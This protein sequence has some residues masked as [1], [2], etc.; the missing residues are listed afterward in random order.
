MTAIT[1][2]THSALR[3]LRGVAKRV[4]TCL[5]ACLTI[6][7]LSQPSVAV[8][9]GNDDSYDQTI[10]VRG[11]NGKIYNKQQS[12]RADPKNNPYGLSIVDKVQTRGSDTRSAD[13]QLN[14]MPDLNKFVNTNL[15]ERVNYSGT[16]G[17][18]IDPANLQLTTDAEVR[19]YFVSEGAGY[20]NMLGFN[21]DS[22]GVDAD[23]SRLIFPD[24]SVPNAFLK[25]DPKAKRSRK[26]PVLPGDF[27]DLGTFSAGQ[28]LDFFLIADDKK[29]NHPVYDANPATNPDG[30]NHMVAF[31]YAI[32]D[33]PYL[34][35][36]F[37]DLFDGGDNDFN[38]LVFV[39]DVGAENVNALVAAPEPGTI[40]A[41]ATAGLAFYHRRR[42]QRVADPAA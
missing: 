34:L 5:V 10:S 30:I 25:G 2:A 16:S 21:V 42:R 41:F 31:S 14:A 18:L 28:Q 33:S 11:D 13:F 32:Q 9:N 39:V 35:I 3:P 27:V 38:D 15:Q 20:H 29:N 23:T 12:W 4:V 22:T 17:R 7:T 37:E 6:V 36:G 26:T 8:A 1:N 19:T 24:A 40:A